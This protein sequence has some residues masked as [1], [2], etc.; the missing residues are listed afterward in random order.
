[1]ERGNTATEKGNHFNGLEGFSGYL[2]R[3]LASKGGIRREKLPLY[4]GEYIWRYNH[5]T[6]SEREKVKRSI[7]LLEREV[8]G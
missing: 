4:L 7:T 3:K 2:K 1:M 8:S 6:E 5:Q